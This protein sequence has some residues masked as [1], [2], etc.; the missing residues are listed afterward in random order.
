MISTE[1]TIVQEQQVDSCLLNAQQSEP[2]ETVSQELAVS[3][4]MSKLRAGERLLMQSTT[5]VERSISKFG[6]VVEQLTQITSMELRQSHHQQPQSVRLYTLR[7]VELITLSQK[8]QLWRKLRSLFKPSREELRMPRELV[9]TEFNSMVLM[10]ILLI[11]SWV[12]PAIKEMMTMVVQSKTELDSVL[13]LL[14]SLSKSSV[15]I[16]LVSSYLQFVTTT[17][18]F[19]LIHT[20][21][22]NIF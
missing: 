11:N 18:M 22:F 5:K 4:T 19:P 2:M 3:G 13:K 6:T 9:S 12:M 20:P 14:M 15:L 10:D 17:T 8:Q 1:N 16:E 21:L 7:T